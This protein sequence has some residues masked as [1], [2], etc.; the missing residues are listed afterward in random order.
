MDQRIL[1]LLHSIPWIQD[2]SGPT[3][4]AFFIAVV[5]VSQILVLPISPID[6]AAG[7]TFGFTKGAL[8]MLVG[9]FLSAWLSGL[10]ARDLARG[11]AERLAQRFP[12][13]QGLD[14]ALAKGGWK[15]ALLCR[16]CPIP[17]GAASYFFGLTRLSHWHHAS[18]TVVAV[19]LPTAIFTTLGAS[20]RASLETLGSQAPSDGPWPKIL[21][22][23]GL[24]AFVLVFR[25]VSKLALQ[26]VHLA[27][28][29][30]GTSPE[31]THDTPKPSSPLAPPQ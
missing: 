17:F 4:P 5:L 9:K 27:Q 7:F 10:L 21:L 15:L 31:P 14:L 30:A 24:V 22:G 6:M 23:L 26:A 16:F 2:P 20:T 13:V 3:A 1:S 28:A 19:L 12:L 25:Q 29:E 8:L 18:A 11:W